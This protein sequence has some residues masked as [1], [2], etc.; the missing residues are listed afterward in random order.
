[1]P[2][3]DF[4]EIV[5]QYTDYVYN[6]AYRILGNPDDARDAAQEAFLSAYR[7]YHRFRG[8]AKVT[9]WLY[10]IAVNASLMKL[11]KEKTARRVV[12]SGDVA[13]REIPN[14]S[15]SV[16]EAPERAALNSELRQRLQHGLSQLPEELR[17]AVVLRDVQGLSNQEAA[18]VLEI[19]VPAFKARL[20]R[21]RLQLREMLAEYLYSPH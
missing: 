20:H 10:R 2:D 7:N 21:G 3:H 5:E 14:T 13:D 16:D 12:Q 4:H 9:T 6:V 18:D 17:V 11:R 15:P 8:Q 19:S 1:M